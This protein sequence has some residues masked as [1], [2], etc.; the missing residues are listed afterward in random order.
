MP[1]Q[2]TDAALDRAAC[3]AVGIEPVYWTPSLRHWPIPTKERAVASLESYRQDALESGD[4][5]RIRKAAA[6][7]VIPVYP[8][9]STWDGV[10]LLVERLEAM[11]CMVSIDL[12]PGRNIVLWTNQG[13]FS[14]ESQQKAETLPEALARAVVDW[15]EAQGG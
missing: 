12:N 4:P 2:L 9:V 11:D 14:V 7:E 5:E 8:R 1:D 15:R 6:C 3:E 13:F 10:R